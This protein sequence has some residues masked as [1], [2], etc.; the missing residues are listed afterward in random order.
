VGHSRIQT[1][2]DIYAHLA[3][4]ARQKAVEATDEKLANLQKGRKKVEKG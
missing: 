1:T 4:A 3:D 2:L